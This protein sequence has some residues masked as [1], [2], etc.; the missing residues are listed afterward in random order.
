MDPAQAPR[1][2][3]IEASTRSRLAEAR[4]HQWL[5][6]VSALENSLRHIRAKKDHVKQ[7]QG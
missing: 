3:Q 2:D 1:L 7:P 5:G 6:E 4:E